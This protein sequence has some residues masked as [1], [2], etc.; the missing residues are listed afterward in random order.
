MI[1]WTLYAVLLHKP[2]TIFTHLPIQVWLNRFITVINADLLIHQYLIWSDCLAFDTQSKIQ[3]PDSGFCILLFQ[4][5][6]WFRI[7]SS[8]WKCNG[9]VW[10]SLTF[11]LK[12][13]STVLNKDMQQDWKELNPCFY[14]T[15][16]KQ[17]RC[18]LY[19]SQR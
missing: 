2:I 4:I 14:F 9:V 12:V 3:Y 18:P 19:Q 13:N 15:V 6:C 17:S 1:E 10:A 7:L 16:A 11:K 5:L 8:Y